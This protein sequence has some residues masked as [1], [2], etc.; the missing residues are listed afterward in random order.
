MNISS[1]YL[2]GVHNSSVA[3]TVAQPVTSAARAP[4][5]ALSQVQQDFGAALRRAS[6]RGAM[7]GDTFLDGEE[8][9]AGA[10]AHMS[11]LPTHNHVAAP[12]AANALQGSANT[13][14][15]PTP[16][17][18]LPDAVPL[19]GTQHAIGNERQWRVNI[20]LDNQTKAS[21]AMRVVHTSTGHWQMRLAADQRTRQQ[22]TPHLDRLRDTLRQHSQGQLSDLGFD[23][24]S[25][26]KG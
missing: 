15:T 4:S 1:T 18:S 21:L 24:D 16:N 14:T 9:R 13:S 23:E 2:S 19:A 5:L 3:S 7:D 26:P 8:G 17:T 20:P 10:A 25:S 22:L 11:C 12:A 6:R